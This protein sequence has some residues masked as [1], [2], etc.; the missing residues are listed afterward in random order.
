MAMPLHP[1][2]LR[3]TLG[4]L[5]YYWPRDRVLALYEEAAAWP[6][7]SIYLGETVCSKRFEMRMAD[8]LEIAKRLADAGKSIG[9]KS[10]NDSPMPA[11]KWC[12]RPAS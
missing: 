1:H 10:P 9:W 12:S 11:R 4:P 8:W 5:L 2:P 3:L 6:V 7:D